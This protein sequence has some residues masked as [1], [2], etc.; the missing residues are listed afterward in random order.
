M[1]QI[2]LTQ[3][4]FALVDD[5]MF[6]ELDKFKWYAEKRGNTFYARMNIYNNGKQYRIYM[7]RYI[8]GLTDSKIKC[9]HKDHN[10]LD[11][12]KSNLRT[13]SNLE[14]SRNQKKVLNTSSRYKGVCFHKR[15]KKWVAHIGV[16]NKLIYI[17]LFRNE[18]DAAKAYNLKASELFGDFA[19]LN[20]F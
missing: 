17:G 2:K 8:L 12:K 16:K 9:D 11:N 14:N 1:K 7:H 5:D 18:Q 10:G 20:T 4:K 13:C 15:D 6:E 19:R 3:N